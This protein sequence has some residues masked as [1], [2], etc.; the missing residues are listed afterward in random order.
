MHYEHYS[1]L[2][3]YKVVNNVSFSLKYNVTSYVGYLM[4]NKGVS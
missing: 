1:T 4:L 2:N 3:L